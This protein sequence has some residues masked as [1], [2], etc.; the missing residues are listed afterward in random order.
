MKLLSA[1]DP[2]RQ[3]YT[4][5]PEIQFQRNQGKSL[6]HDQAV[7]LADFAAVQEKLFCPEWIPV[8]NVAL[9]VG[10]DMQPLDPDFAFPD[11]SD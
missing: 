7:Q 8:I 6:P 3:F 4:S 10:A 9:F 5:V 2:Q 11:L 1:A